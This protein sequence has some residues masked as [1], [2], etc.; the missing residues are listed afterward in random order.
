MRSLRTVV[1][2]VGANFQ[3]A[4][5]RGFQL[6]PAITSLV[7]P[8]KDCGAII[9]VPLIKKFLSLQISQHLLVIR[10]VYHHL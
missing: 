3:A 6:V 5:K 4:A 10:S 9:V 8:Q 2:S 1:S 7:H